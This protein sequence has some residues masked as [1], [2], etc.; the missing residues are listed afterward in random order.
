MGCTGKRRPLYYDTFTQSYAALQS[1]V[2]ERL[3]NGFTVNNAGNTIVY[4]NGD[5]LQP[6]SSKTVGGNEG[7]VYKGR[8]D[9]QFVTPSP[10]PSTIINLAVVTQKYYLPDQFSL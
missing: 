6:G 1:V 5:P 4:V 10:A 3:C 2:M 8:C 7:E 9:L